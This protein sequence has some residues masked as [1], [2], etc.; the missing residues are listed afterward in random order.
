M[1]L[2]YYLSFIIIIY[3]YII[4]NILEIKFN[5]NFGFYQSIKSLINKGKRILILYYNFIKSIIIDI[6]SEA[7][8]LL[9]N[10]ENRDYNGAYIRPDPIFIDCIL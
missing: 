10:K 6:K 4:V 3:I 9:R 1:G 8:I 2:E 7:S 5:K